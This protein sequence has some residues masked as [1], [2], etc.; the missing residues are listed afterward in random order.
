MNWQS[1]PIYINNFNNLARGFRRL[2][3]WLR[4]AGYENVTV[5]DNGSTWGPL[6]EYYERSPELVVLRVGENLGPYAVWNLDLHNKGGQFVVTDPDVV[7]AVDCPRDVVRK[8]M[9]VRERFPVA[10]VG[11]SLRI[12]NLPEHYRERERVVKWEGQFWTGI[13][14]SGDVYHAAVD[15][16]F[17][18]YDQGMRAWPAGPYL[19]LA[20]PYTFEHLPWYEDSGRPSAELEFYRSTRRQGDTNW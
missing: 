6:L 14:P 18:L 10:K 7:P 16:T 3:E 15:T 5:V 17:A 19:R 12:D 4:D 8:L 13:D 9:E 1:V 20:P 11:V 2:V